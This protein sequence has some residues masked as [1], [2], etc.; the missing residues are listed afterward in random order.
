MRRADPPYRIQSN[1]EYALPVLTGMDLARQPR[2]LGLSTMH[3]STDNAALVG[4][5]FD[6]AELQRFEDS[7]S[8]AVGKAGE[9][10]LSRFMGSL[11]VDSKSSQ[12]GKDLVTDVDKRSQE[13]IASEMSERFPDH[14]LL[15]EEDQKDGGVSAEDIVW[16]VDPVDGTHNFVNQSATFAVSA[17]ILYRGRPIAGAIWYPWPNGPGGSHIVRASLGNGAHLGDR[18]LSVAEPESESGRPVAGRLVTLPV[19]ASRGLRFSSDVRGNVGDIRVTGCAAQEMLHVATAIYQYSIVGVAA[20]WDFA[21]AAIIVTEA[22][23]KLLTTDDE[24]QWTDFSGWGAPY[25]NDVD[26]YERMRKWRGLMLAAHP[27]TADYLKTNIVPKRPSLL[28]RLA[29]RL[30]SK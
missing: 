8:V 7:L 17:G 29:M 10:A 1:C 11:Q 25:A 30:A 6:S 16:S 26:T 2:F 20:V 18:R 14:Q 3:Q 27:K 21:A 28:G 12:P 13:M 23:G 24:R 15:G 5:P 4:V 9:Y 19:G 22:G